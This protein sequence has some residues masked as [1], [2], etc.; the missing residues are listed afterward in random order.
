MGSL[1]YKVIDPRESCIWRSLCLAI[2][3]EKLRQFASRGASRGVA[4]V[5]TAM[6]SLGSLQPADGGKPE[7]R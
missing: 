4:K 2:A 7:K 5:T 3:T 6:Q 1:A